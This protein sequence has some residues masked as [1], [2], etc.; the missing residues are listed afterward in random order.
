MNS[1]QKFKTLSPLSLFSNGILLSLALFGVLLFVINTYHIPVGLP[2]LLAVAALSTLISLIL[3]SLPRYRTPLSLLLCVALAVTAWQ[4]WSVLRDG[5]LLTYSAVAETLT[6]AVGFPGAFT[7]QISRSAES[8]RFAV[9]FFLSLFTA[10]ESWALGWSI[11]RRHALLPT[12]LLTFPLLLPAFLAELSPPW[13]CLVAVAVCWLALLFTSLSR[14]G[15][16]RPAARLTLLALPVSAALLSGFLLLSPPENYT[17][18]AWALRAQLLARDLHVRLSGAVSE[19]LSVLPQSAARPD[20]QVNLSSAGPRH[21]TGRTLFTLTSELPGTLYLRGVSSATYTGRSWEPL[22]ENALATLAALS[23][24]SPLVSVSALLPAAANF[25]ST[26]YTVTLT[27]QGAPTRLIYTPYQPAEIGQ[28]LFTDD[29]YFLSDSP[30]SEY[31]VSFFSQSEVPTPQPHPASAEEERYRQFV[32]QQYLAVPPELTPALQRWTAAAER[33]ALHAGGPVRPSGGSE[34]TDR[35]ALAQWYAGLLELTTEYD[36]ETPFTPDSSDFVSHFLLTSRRGYCVH[37]ASAAVLLL[38]SEGIPARYVSGYL[39]QVPLSGSTVVPDSAAHAWVELYLDGYGWYPV[40]VT[41]AAEEAPTEEPPAEAPA[42]QVPA[43]TPPPQ[44]PPPEPEQPPEAS[45][46]AAEQPSEH[47]APPY[48]LL[49][50]ILPLLLLLYRV[51]L[52]LRWVVLRRE[53]DSNRAARLL[54]GWFLRLARFG[55]R[56]DPRVLQL[57]RKARFSQHTLTSAE[58][59]ELFSLLLLEIDRCARAQPL[60][61]RPIF[62]YLFRFPSGNK[63]APRSG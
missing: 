11:V 8:A 37:Y 38:R 49:L 36:L 28:A 5:A 6:R 63:S 50:L 53:R 3:F 24:G 58:Q 62:A 16:P 31:S 18:P 59:D 48:L 21:Y 12:F 7:P 45:P 61:R 26:R 2:P 14:K 20:A 60:W 56:T 33:E 27:P 25:S 30:L 47:T 55:G 23:E 22:S 52:H 35:I 41:P 32:Y 57:V 39:A 17:Q 44:S 9:F 43:E 40:E 1:S 51:S 42:P 54:Y 29:S 19:G 15:A 4:N 34:Y 46:P 10:L 13:P